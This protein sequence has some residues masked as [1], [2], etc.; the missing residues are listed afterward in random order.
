MFLLKL[1]WNSSFDALYW[2]TVNISTFSTWTKWMTVIEWLSCL[3]WNLM[4]ATL[5]Y[6]YIFWLHF[7]MIMCIV[8]TIYIMFECWFLY[9]ALLNLYLIDPSLERKASFFLKWFLLLPLGFTFCNL[10]TFWV[11]TWWIEKKTTC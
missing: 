3:W 11:L 2:W 7:P 4:H 10:G 5:C 9:L 6:V 1:I 8:S